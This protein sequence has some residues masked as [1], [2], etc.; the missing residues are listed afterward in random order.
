MTPPR[1]KFRPDL[2]NADEL[3]PARGSTAYIGN[4]PD[5]DPLAELQIRRLANR[6]GHARL[7]RRGGGWLEVC[8]DPAAHER[9]AADL[10]TA[11]EACGFIPYEPGT[12]PPPDGTATIATSYRRPGR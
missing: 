4:T 10:A 8:P 12:R 11:L 2:D 1:P 7:P 9:D 5:D 3:I 6:H